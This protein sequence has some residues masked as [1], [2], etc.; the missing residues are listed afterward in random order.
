[1]VT[2]SPLV[3]RHVF[4]RRWARHG[5]FAAALIFGSLLVGVL[6]YH[7]FEGQSF[8]DA[9]LNA[10]MI[11]AGEGPVN[12]LRT[13]GGKLFATFYALFAGVIFLVAVGVFLTPL[14]HRLFHKYHLDAEERARKGT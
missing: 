13:D 4:A 8:L 6:G 5:V 1:M 2:N 9:L 3:P 12:P 14:A 10:A 7:V 11:L